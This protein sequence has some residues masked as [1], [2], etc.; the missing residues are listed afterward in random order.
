MQGFDIE[1]DEDDDDEEFTQFHYVDEDE[2]AYLE[3]SQNPYIQEFSTTILQ[4][5]CLKI[6]FHRLLPSR[7]SI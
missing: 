5:V 2:D 3:R 6:G 7:I 4:K 1:D